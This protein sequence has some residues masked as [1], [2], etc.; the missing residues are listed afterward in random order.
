[1]PFIMRKKK[2]QALST[3]L[4]RLLI[5]LA[6]KCNSHAGRCFHDDR[7]VFRD[8]DGIL[9]FTPPFRTVQ[10]CHSIS[11]AELIILISSCEYSLANTCMFMI[12]GLAGEPK[13]S[14]YKPLLL[15]V[16]VDD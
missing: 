6:Y 11:V 12:N 7:L 2:T 1:M 3:S 15:A 10:A 13:H 16:H 14:F 5:S 4:H 8:T 9:K